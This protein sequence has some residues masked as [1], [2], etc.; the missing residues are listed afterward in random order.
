MNLLLPKTDDY[1][2]RHT[3][4]RAKNN[5]FLWQTLKPLIK[6]LQHYHIKT[7]SHASIFWAL[8]CNLRPAFVGTQSPKLTIVPSIEEKEHTKMLQL[9]LYALMTPMSTT[10]HDVFPHRFS[11][12]KLADPRIVGPFT[13]MTSLAQTV[14]TVLNKARACFSVWVP[15]LHWD[16][17]D[18]ERC[19]WE[20]VCTKLVLVKMWDY[21]PV[22]SVQNN[23]I[24]SLLQ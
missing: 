8:T 21:L 13:R 6:T 4:T 17:Y 9:Y 15:L 11:F 1:N 12:Q 2:L 20:D 19:E 3:T 23:N 24:L 16:C 5:R 18:Y 14:P 10:T 7:S 22:N